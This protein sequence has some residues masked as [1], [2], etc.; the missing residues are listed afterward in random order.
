MEGWV[1][2][3]SWVCT[4]M[5]Y[6]SADKDNINLQQETGYGQGTPDFKT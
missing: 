1:D 5:A 3:G 6:L 4:E 2:L